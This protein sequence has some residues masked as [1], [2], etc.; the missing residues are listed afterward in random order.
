M[1]SH[2][3]SGSLHDFTHFFE[4]GRL[5]QV[6]GQVGLLGDDVGYR[7]TASRS[8]EYDPFCVAGDLQLS[9]RCFDGLPQR[10]RIGQSCRGI[11]LQQRLGLEDLVDCEHLHQFQHG[12]HRSL[13]QFALG[14]RLDDDPEQQVAVASRPARLARMLAQ[15]CQHGL[16]SRV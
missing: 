1:M 11:A 13:A 14:Q 4:F 5:Q 7:K 8:L 12:R 15:H 2:P 6:G 16:P 9:G 3:F 10:G